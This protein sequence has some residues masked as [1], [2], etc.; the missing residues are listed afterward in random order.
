MKITYILFLILG[1]YLVSCAETASKKIGNENSA[2][3]ENGTCNTGLTCENDIC[4][5]NNCFD[6]DCT[7][8]FECNSE[9]GICDIPKEGYCLKDSDC[10]TL[11][12]EI[13]NDSNRCEI[14]DPCDGNPCKDNMDGKT[15]CKLDEKNGYICEE[16]FSD[17]CKPNP[18][19]DNTDGKTKCELSGNDDGYICVE[20]GTNPCEPNPCK[21]NTDGKTKCELSGNDDGYV[22]VESGT[23]PCKDNPCENDPDGKT[24]CKVD[25][26]MPHGYI[27]EEPIVLDPC[28]S[29]PCE[30]NLEGKT[31]CEIDD[32]VT[33]G[34]KC[35]CELG[36]LFD[37]DMSV[38]VEVDCSTQNE[39][40]ENSKKCLGDRL[41][42]CIQ[43][44]QTLCFSW[45]TADSNN[46]TDCGANS[47][48]D[49]GTGNAYCECKECNPDTFNSV[50]SDDLISFKYCREEEGC[51]TIE[52]LT[53]GTGE[54]CELSEAN[55][56]ECVATTCVN[57]CEEDDITCSTSDGDDSL[58]E[59]C[60]L[61][62]DGCYKY[63]VENALNCSA[64]N[65]ECSVYHGDTQCIGGNGSSRCNDEGDGVEILA[66]GIWI[67]TT[68][69]SGDNYSGCHGGM[70]GSDVAYSINIEEGSHLHLRLER[71]SGAPALGYDIAVYLVKE[72]CHN[73]SFCEEEDG[74]NTAILDLE[75]MQAGLYH[76]II[77]SDEYLGLNASFDY[78]LTVDL[79]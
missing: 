13:C 59:D 70:G 60:K 16:P 73:L 46:L 61:F 24:I 34:Y 31:K 38:C 62:S 50:C 15:V 14:L 11:I 44:E 64:L 55:R 66:S 35:L 69:G 20:S 26:S 75:N 76:I 21:D 47:C 6:I 23:S 72:D 19:K 49:D 27:C 37:E 48:I 22:C 58:V 32:S 54:H 5:K 71:G 12:D 51:F 25:D 28:E 78:E 7:E 68:Q 52:N 17:K 77:D 40:E 65:M 2:C 1:F 3:Y 18:C 41:A 39:C 79:Q 29:N 8:G 42:N 57:E 74:S 33:D 67:G 45:E 4:V 9:T 30:G 43:D 53:C 63:D 56:L 36:Y 10:N